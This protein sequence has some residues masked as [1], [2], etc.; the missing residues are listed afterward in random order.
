M[1]LQKSRSWAP[2]I[3]RVLSVEEADLRILNFKVIM[4]QMTIPVMGI[5]LVLI[6]FVIH[7]LSH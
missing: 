6:K 5:L 1:V 2:L 3:R 7:P 4:V